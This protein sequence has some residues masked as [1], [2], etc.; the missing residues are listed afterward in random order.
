MQISGCNAP[1][2]P[3]EELTYD[4]LDRLPQAVKAFVKEVG[5][6]LILEG[7]QAHLQWMLH[8]RFPVLAQADIGSAFRRILIR[9]AGPEFRHIASRQNDHV[10]VAKHLIMMY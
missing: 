3:S 8:V 4:S 6:N 9:A 1:G 7:E 10:N 5:K 2:A